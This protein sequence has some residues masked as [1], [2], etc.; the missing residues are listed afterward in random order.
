MPAIRL[1]ATEIEAALASSDLS[2]WRLKNGKLHREY[3]FANFV[4]AFGF[5]SSVALH[6]ESKN[7][8]PEWFNVYGTVIVDLTTHDCGGVSARDLD[9]ART[10]ESFAKRAT[11]S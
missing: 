2:A 5:M 1:S 10:M 6:A 7:H 8:H 3:R 9:L 11:R 4:D